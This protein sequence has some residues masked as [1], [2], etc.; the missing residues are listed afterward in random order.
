[1]SSS[2]F[3]QHQL[4]RESGKGRTCDLEKSLWDTPCQHPEMVIPRNAGGFFLPH[5]YGFT[6]S[7]QWECPRAAIRHSHGTMRNMD[8]GNSDLSLTPQMYFLLL[9]KLLQEQPYDAKL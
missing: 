7:L 4:W 3:V 6:R 9:S 1:M 5:M 2:A 8:C